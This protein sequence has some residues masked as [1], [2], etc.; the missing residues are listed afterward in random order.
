MCTRG[1]KGVR[2]SAAPP[3]L[4]LQQDAPPPHFCGTTEG[5]KI[6][7]SSKITNRAGDLGPPLSDGG[8]RVNHHVKRH[9]RPTETLVLAAGA[10]F[11]GTFF[12]FSQFLGNSDRKNSSS[13]RKSSNIPPIGLMRGL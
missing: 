11:Q 4:L 10:D 3:V 6:P 9:R 5:L 13:H 1:T 7:R 8:G 12:F 2:L